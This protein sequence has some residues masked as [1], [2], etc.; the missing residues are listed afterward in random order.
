MNNI[1][2]MNKVRQENILNKLVRINNNV[3]TWKEHIKSGIFIK[4]EIGE[5]NKINY[6]RIKCNRMD[7]NK[8][9][10]TYIKKCEEM[11]KTYRL[12]QKEGSFINVPK[13][14][15]DYFNDNNY[16]NKKELNDIF[17]VA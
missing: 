17:G 5:T 12:Y 1:K 8:D 13:M 15:F 2:I 11:K 10:D 6:N 7:N 16:L 4:S 14:I 3:K 9:Q